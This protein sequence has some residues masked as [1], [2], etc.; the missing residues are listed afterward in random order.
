MT[1]SINAGS[2]RLSGQSAEWVVTLALLGVCAAAGLSGWLSSA[3]EQGAVATTLPEPTRLRTTR[4]QENAVLQDWRQRIE[5]DFSRR[6]Q[7]QRQQAQSQALREQA[8]ALALARAAAEA[9]ERAAVEAEA[10]A[11]RAEQART[12]VAAPVAVAREASPRQPAASAPVAAAKTTANIDWSSCDTPAYPTVS[13]RRGEEGIVTMA[14]DVSPAGVAGGG[15]VVQSSGSP[16]LDHRALDALGKC[17]FSPATENG[18]P[19]AG[20]AQVRFA[21][22]L[23]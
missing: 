12:S 6:E 1:E 5:R 18:S 14:F 9:A 21:W 4:E 13:I 23:Q 10:R 15:R 19:V 8:Q 17:R 20:E 16:R 11:R 3:P 7:N 2:R 22:K